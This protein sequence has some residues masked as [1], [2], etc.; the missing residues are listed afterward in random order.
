[1]LNRF[2]AS[3]L[4]AIAHTLVIE[5]GAY[6]IPILTKF[7]QLNICAKCYQI[8]GQTFLYVQPCKYIVKQ[9]AH[10]WSNSA[11]IYGKSVQL[12]NYGQV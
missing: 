6:G 4:S 9:N 8:Y 10:I 12:I 2:L 1:M 5:G 7:S 3:R 11:I